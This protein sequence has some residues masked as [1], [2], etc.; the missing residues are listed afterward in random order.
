MR[1]S[2]RQLKL[3]RTA[4]A[5]LPI[6]TRERFLIDLAQRLGGH[7]SD[8]AVVEAINVVL[9]RAVV[10]PA[11]LCDANPRD[12]EV[13]S[14]ELRHY[15]RNPRCRSRLPSP[16]PT[17]TPHSAPGGALTS[18]TATAALSVT[19]S[20][21]G[22]TTVSSGFAVGASARPTTAGFQSSTA[23]LTQTDL[24]YRNGFRRPQKPK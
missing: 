1:L 19:A 5:S 20:L 8:N 7:P 12:F 10:T 11:Y 21:S 4:A 3:I 2:A 14:A 15:C 9:D 18:T 23:P 6:L 13:M 16:P 24:G 22:R 17:R